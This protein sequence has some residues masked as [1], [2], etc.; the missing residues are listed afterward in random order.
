MKEPEGQLARWLE[1]LDE[2][3]FEIIHRPGQLHG[4]TDSLSRGPCCQSC[5]CK[6]PGPSLQ[7]VNVSHQAVQCELD[8]GINQMILSP[9]GVEGHS[10]STAVNLVGADETLSADMDNLE[11]PERIYLTKTNEP[12][13]FGGWSPEEL[14]LAQEANPDIAPVRAWMEA[15][16]ERPPMGNSFTMQSSHQDILEPVKATLH[17]GWNTG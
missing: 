6:L 10:A 8:S 14:H 3:N 4:N 5:P 13:L 12:E 2:Y 16:R 15:S 1:R 7:P 11:P 9:V 17:P